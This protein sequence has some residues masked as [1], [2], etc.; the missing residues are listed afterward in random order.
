M[1]TTDTSHDQPTDELAM[2]HFEEQLWA[3]IQARHEDGTWTRPPATPSPVPPTVP[4]PTVVHRR[5]VRRSLA[6]AAALAVIAAAAALSTIGG[7]GGGGGGTTAGRHPDAAATPAADEIETRTI[8]AIDEALADSIVHTVDDFAD[9]SEIGDNESWYDEGS[10]TERWV[11]RNPDGTPSYDVGP[12][13]APA[14]DDEPT[15]TVMG[16]EVD[17]CASQY[18]ESKWLT[19]PPLNEAGMIRDLLADGGLIADGT[20]VV[21]GRDLIRLREAMAVATPGGPPQVRD[22]VYY[23]DPETYRPVTARFQT[24]DPEQHTVTFEYLP[25][26]AESLSQLV[27]AIPEGFTQ[28]A[29]VRDKEERSTAGCG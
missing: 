6:A 12:A 29:Q 11:A 28:V 25:R 19:S 7:N 23:V 20:E 21:D 3:Q 4:A 18:A 24:G 10:G 2:P 1:A 13:V 9:N 16:R 8:A 5:A 17:H 22:A 15:A 27:P 14:P 26:T